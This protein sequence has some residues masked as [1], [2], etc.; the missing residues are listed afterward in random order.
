M[1]KPPETE[2]EIAEEMRELGVDNDA[3]GS[4]DLFMS[5][6]VVKVVAGVLV[7]LLV[8]GLLVLVF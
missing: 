2:E 7:I 4:P 5:G 1:E 3:T 8:L 6:P